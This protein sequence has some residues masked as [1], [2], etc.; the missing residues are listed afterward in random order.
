[1]KRALLLV[2]TMAACAGPTYVNVPMGRPAALGFR[3]VEAARGRRTLELEQPACLAVLLVA[4]VDPAR[5]RAPYH[6]FELFP[7]FAGRPRCFPAGRHPL[8]YDAGTLEHGRRCLGAEAT[9]YFCGPVAG[10][11]LGFG[12]TWALE[13]YV[14]SDLPVD[15]RQLAAQLND[16]TPMMDDL[17]V[18]L[19]EGDLRTAGRAIEELIADVPGSPM[20][21]AVL[22]DGR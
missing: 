5:G 16:A 6:S 10:R 22:R 19:W 3:I 11:D 17:G 21:A 13:L 9:A 20:W 7:R 4:A 2:V 14:V 18:L 1:M 12:A 8:P 15:E